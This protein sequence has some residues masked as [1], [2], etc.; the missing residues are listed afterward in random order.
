MVDTSIASYRSS[1]GM[2]S[3]LFV[4]VAPAESR[5][6]PGCMNDDRRRLFHLGVSRNFSLIESKF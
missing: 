4:R 2:S 6:N 1:I 3:P 5:V